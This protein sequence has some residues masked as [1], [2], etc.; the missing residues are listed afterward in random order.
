MW[1][2]HSASFFEDSKWR[3]IDRDHEG[4]GAIALQ[5]VNYEKLQFC[6]NDYLCWGKPEDDETKDWWVQNTGW[7]IEQS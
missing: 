1:S 3:V 7:L 5:S 6:H 2:D 4:D